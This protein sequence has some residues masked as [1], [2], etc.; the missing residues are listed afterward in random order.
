MM[1][2]LQLFQSLDYCQTGERR[3]TRVYWMAALM[4]LICGGEAG[5]GRS[6]TT[7]TMS[8]DSGDLRA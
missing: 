4:T 6:D 2:A 8:E 7:G 1:G 5:C 3:R